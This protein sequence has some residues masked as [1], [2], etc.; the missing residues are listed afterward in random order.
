LHSNST[1]ATITEAVSNS[2]KTSGTN[3]ILARAEIPARAGKQALAVMPASKLAAA[4]MLP[5]SRTPARSGTLTK[6]ISQQQCAG[7]LLL[8][9]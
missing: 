6:K 1:A 8:R 5:T 9:R 2:E 3:G 7:R 4:R